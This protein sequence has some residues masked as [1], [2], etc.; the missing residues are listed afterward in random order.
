MSMKRHLRY[1]LALVLPVLTLLAIVEIALVV[2]SRK[3]DMLSQVIDIQT[4][5]ALYAK[6]EYLRRFEGRRIVFIGDSVIY[7][8]RME[9]AGD[10]QWQ[11]HTIPAQVGQRLNA[12]RPQHDIMTKTLVMN[13]AMNGA[14]PADLEQ[15]V[16]LVT[17]L[18]PDCIVADISLRAF[19]ADF[20][21]EGSRFSRSWL[22]GMHVDDRF[23]LRTEAPLGEA[24]ETALRDFATSNWQ[25]YQ[26]RDFA[27]WRI[28]DGQ[29]AGAV[30]RIRDWLDQ[31]ML[32]KPVAASDPLDDI[33]LT[34]R[35][36]NRHDSITMA[37][38]NPQ[39]AALKR[40]LDQLA[41]SQQ[42]AMFFYATEEKKQL[43]ELIDTARYQKLQ[44][45]LARLFVDYAA[46]GIMYVPPLDSIPSVHYLDYG[47][48]DAA[49][50]AIVAGRLIEA[51]LGQLMNRPART[52]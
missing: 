7:G 22:A 30:R 13:L 1:V 24:F 2:I 6:L 12:L 47:H 18:K 42:C 43:T 45:E 39:L 31:K 14:L 29:P 15:V 26:L 33:L 27:Q 9:E 37:A 36:K 28:F 38:E 16:R 50:N 46:R 10:A 5:G 40:M 23:N 48:L 8:R 11:A 35:A 25:V 34:M 44:G 41:N 52:Q 3:T 17:P 19:S 20:I 21:P 4:P 49:G 51:G 32:S